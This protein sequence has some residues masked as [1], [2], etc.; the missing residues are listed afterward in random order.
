[1]IKSFPQYQQL[2]AMDCGATC[3]SMIAKYYGKN[4]SSQTLRK[5]SYITRECVSLLGISDAAESIGI[6]DANPYYLPAQSIL[7]YFGAIRFERVPFATSGSNARKAKPE[8]ENKN[9]IEQSKIKIAPN[10]ANSTIA[11]NFGKTQSGLL[12]IYGID[13]KI[14]K[15]INVFAKESINIDVSTLNKGVYILKFTSEYNGSFKYAKLIV[16]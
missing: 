11:I 6:R 15:K 7:K 2:D 1:M 8:I 9:T 14:I 5:R 16:Q 10:P 4:Y 3:L 12:I 13:G